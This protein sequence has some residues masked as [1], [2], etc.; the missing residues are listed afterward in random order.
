MTLIDTSA[1]IEALRADG[2]SVIRSRVG[3]LLETGHA[4]LCDI[5]ILELWNGTRGENEQ[6][7]LRRITETLDCVPNTQTVWTTANSLATACRKRGVTVP[8]TDLLVAATVR[9][10]GLDLLEADRHFGMIPD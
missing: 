7:K 1:W 2:D 4:V 6:S 5:V 8:A 3:A 10:H 9:V